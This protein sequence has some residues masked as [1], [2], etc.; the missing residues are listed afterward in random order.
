[1]GFDRSG[2]RLAAHVV[3]V[4]ATGGIALWTLQRP[5]SAILS[6]LAIVATMAAV[7][8]L[9]AS[10]RR[11]DR[12]LVRFVEAIG[13]VDLSQRFGHGAVGTALDAAMR[14]LAADR[15]RIGE[16]ARFQAA[17]VEEAPVALLTIDENR[18]ICLL[19]AAARGIFRHLDGGSIAAVGAEDEAL[20]AV[21]DPATGRLGRSLITLSSVGGDQRAVVTATEMRRA[22]RPLRLVAVELIG[23][24]L[25]AAEVAAQADLV[26][27]LTHEIMNSLT[28]VTSLAR[29]AATLMARVPEGDENTTDA[30]RAI[31][32]VADRAEGLLGFV[33]SYRQYAT[34]PVVVRRTCDARRWAEDVVALLGEASFGHGVRVGIEV[35]PSSATFAA[36]PDLL[37]QA[38][39]NLLKNAAEA[40]AGYVQ[41]S[42]RRYHDRVDLVIADDGAGFDAEVAA[43]MFLPFFTSK[44]TGTGIGLSL[45]RQVAVA[46]GGSIRAQI[47]DS[48]GSVFLISIPHYR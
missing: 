14:R 46:H 37:T 5:D 40:G 34:L 7:A 20:A 10:V 38:L 22:G 9:Y 31:Q 28:P 6:L 44:A 32:I 2:L 12:E 42:I 16:E 47:G 18:T 48:G 26:R 13:H 43:D 24:E 19:N 1:M 25:D 33:N 21:L 41:L 27:V 4:L 45:A 29:S 35:V 15:Q 11:H 30:R 36:D 17:M 3:A 8:S 39:L 23:R